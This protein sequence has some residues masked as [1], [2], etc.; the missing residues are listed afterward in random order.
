MLI[1]GG[2]VGFDT[3]NGENLSSSQA[4]PAKQTALLLLSLTPFPVLNPAA[5]LCRQMYF[6][7]Y[8]HMKYHTIKVRPY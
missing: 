8:I 2:A 7:K 6:I 4:Q 5:P 1:Q 3:G